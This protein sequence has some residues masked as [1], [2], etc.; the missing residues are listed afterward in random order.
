MKFMLS[1]LK[2][3]LLIGAWLLIISPTPAIA[4]TVGLS[5]SPPVVEVLLAPTKKAVQ[6]F[7]LKNQGEA[8]QLIPTLHTASPDGT[9]GHIRVAPSPVSPAGIPLVA[10]L[11]PYTFGQTISLPAGGSLTLSLTLEG[12]SVDTPV[13]TY[14]ALVFTPRSLGST[15]GLTSAAPAISA[16]VF[17]TLTPITVIPANLELSNFDPPFLHDTAL[18]FTLNPELKNLAGV[19]IHPQTELTILNSRGQTVHQAKFAS[20]LIL[21]DSTRSLGPLTWYPRWSNLGPHRLRLTVTTLG[22]TKL[23]E[24]ERTVWLLPIRGLIGL[25]LIFFILAVLI[26]QNRRRP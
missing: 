9:T 4:Q 21:Q 13:D 10:R 2:Y 23:T 1:P 5:I 24:V 18:P 6:T 20:R 14:L 11:S 15:L 26:L 8:I 17:T 12:A 7:T 3:Y 19:M 25:S 22:G 16:L